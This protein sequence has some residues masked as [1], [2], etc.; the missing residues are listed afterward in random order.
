MIHNANMGIERVVWKFT[1]EYPHGPS[2]S[3]AL[4]EQ[5]RLGNTVLAGDWRSRRLLL[6]LIDTDQED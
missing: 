1:A 2:L 4:D 5:E 6:A 3:E